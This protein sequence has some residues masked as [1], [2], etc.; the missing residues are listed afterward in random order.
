[1]YGKFI[2]GVVGFVVSLGAVAQAP[3]GSRPGDTVSITRGIN[4]TVLMNL[5]ASWKLGHAAKEDRRLLTEYVPSAEAVT[6]WSEMVSVQIML[7]LANSGKLPL[8][9]MLQG[10]SQVMKTVCKDVL[11]QQFGEGV[12]DGRPAAVALIGCARAPAAA[13][14]GLRQGDSE[15]GLHVV[16]KG[17][18]DLYFI[19]KSRRGPGVDPAT[20]PRQTLKPWQEFLSSIKLCDLNEPPKECV[21]RATR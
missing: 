9:G 15:I 6:N 17:R 19:T 4:E 3:G 1:M 18:D 13:P 7:G 5:P 20:Y 2:A 21:N 12:L 11:F 16:V 14:T 10:A 8:S